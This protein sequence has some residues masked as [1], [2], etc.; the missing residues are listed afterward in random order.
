MACSNPKLARVSPLPHLVSLRRI[1]RFF[2][3]YST[4]LTLSLLLAYAIRFDMWVPQEEA[5][6]IP[7]I[8]AGVVPI[9]LLFLYAFHQF[10][11]LPAYFGIPALL[12]MA[13]ALGCSGLLLTAARLRWHLGYALP[14][15]VILLDGLLGLFFLSSLCYLWRLYRHSHWA[16]LFLGFQSKRDRRRRVGIIGAGHAGLSLAQ[17]LQSNPRL[18]LHP[19]AFFD[20]DPCKWHAR[21][22]DIPV[23]GSPDLLAKGIARAYQIDEIILSMPSAPAIRINQIIEIIRDVGLDYKTVPSLGEMAVGKY[24]V[25]NLRTVQ[26]E[27][28]LGRE[29]VQLQAEEIRKLVAG[30]RVMVTGAGGSIGSE[31]SRQVATHC[32]TELLLVE[33]S[34]V[35]LF[36]IEQELIRRGHGNIARALVA[37]VLDE[38]RLRRIFEVH[39][40]GIIF[41]AAAHKHVPMMES[42]PEEAIKNNTFGT[43]L[44]ARL[45]QEYGVERFV[46]ISTDKAINPTSVMGATKR[47]A[48]MLLQDLVARNHT[49]TRFMAVRF[50][51]V[52][53][54][55]GSVVPL[56][57]DQIAAGGPVTV[58]HPKM[59]RYFM[60]IPEAVGLVLQ[61][62]VL[63]QGGEIFVLDMGKPVRI[64]DLARQMIEL[65]GFEPGKD[66]RIEFTGMR[67]GE[68][69][70]E[71]I[72]YSLESVNPTAH[73]KIMLL[74]GA[75]PDSELLKENLESLEHALA[76]ANPE[77]LKRLLKVAVPE[78]QASVPVEKRSPPS[79]I[80]PTHDLSRRPQPTEPEQV[81]LAQV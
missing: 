67:P 30:R 22:W 70:F 34:E 37:D 18:G 73:A 29:P 69:L 20:D 25:S 43:A 6:Y 55:S 16:V 9:Q 68:K 59:T 53:G 36:A 79:P 7:M 31:L 14:F 39:G 54:S 23:V 76:A 24:K 21:A 46:L 77:Q 50:G 60:T 74:R 33:R 62:T 42:Q 78:Y 47:L 81:A 49:S 27:D 10:D 56:F 41:H 3:I 51:N 61:S 15:G 8:L 80:S 28:L 35:Q 66:I 52:L 5:K 1:G 17:E 38:S 40:P 32:P 13:G 58:T 63:G 2:V 45:A 4:A 44:V 57:K 64:L 75:P 19:V 71:E 11:L 12:R 48:E 72:S 65:C 26:I